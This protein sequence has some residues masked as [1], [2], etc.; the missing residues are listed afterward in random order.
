M[1]QLQSSGAI[2]LHDP[3]DRRWRCQLLAIS[4]RRTGIGLGFGYG[5]GYGCGCGFGFGFGCRR[6]SLLD[7]WPAQRQP[8]EQPASIMPAQRDIE[9]WKNTVKKYMGKIEK[10]K[11]Q[12]D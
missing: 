2:K 8:N 6:F 7:L 12:L 9:H 1:C 4:H 11:S 5:Y 10:E 3:T